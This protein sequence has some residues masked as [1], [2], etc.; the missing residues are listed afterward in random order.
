MATGICDPN[1]SRAR[2]HRSLKLG[3]KL[4]YLK[5][6]EKFSTSEESKDCSKKLQ[7]SCKSWGGLC[8]KSENLQSVLLAKPNSQENII[9]AELITRQDLFKLNKITHQEGLEDLMILLTDDDYVTG[10][11]A[12]LPSN[13]DALTIIK[14]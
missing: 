6:K 12:G 1:K 5:I 4:K 10:S 13:K 9:K 14:G 3:S 2:H 11:R 8:T 7:P